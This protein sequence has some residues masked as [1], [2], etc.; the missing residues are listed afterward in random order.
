MFNQVPNGEPR[1]AWKLDLQIVTTK[2]HRLSS[3]CRSWVFYLDPGTPA[4]VCNIKRV[5]F[6]VH[7]FFR[8]ERS[9]SFHQTIK[10]FVSQKKV[11]NCCC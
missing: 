6:H 10:G 3:Y 1:N 2:N 8:G 7:F 9:H 11:Q 4:I 5:Y